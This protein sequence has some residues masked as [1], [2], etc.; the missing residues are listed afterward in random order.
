MGRKKS[1]PSA[2]EKKQGRHQ[3]AVWSSSVAAWP[4][5]G[6][7]PMQELRAGA[8]ARLERAQNGSK[9]PRS[10]CILGL[11]VAALE[12]RR[13]RP[14]ARRRASGVLAAERGRKRRRA[15]SFSAF[16][17]PFILARA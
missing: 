13:R 7:V 15:L 11:G 6:G 2:R 5:Q 10:E 16:R 4:F 3:L 8:Y 12:R 17:G 1:S 9:A 14:L